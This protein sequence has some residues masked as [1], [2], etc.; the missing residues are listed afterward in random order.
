[1]QLRSILVKTPIIIDNH[2]DLRTFD[3]VEAAEAYMEVV[4]V[5]RGE[6]IARDADGHL[7]AIE[8]VVGEAK[9]FWGLW[10]T[11]VKKV[12]LQSLAQS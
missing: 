2:G 12:R 5:E 4:D 9:L 1:M 3:S 10:R 8:V 6:Y 11:K 7:L